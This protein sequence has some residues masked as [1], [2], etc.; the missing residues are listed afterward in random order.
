MKKIV[1]IGVS[2]CKSG[3]LVCHLRVYCTDFGLRENKIGLSLVLVDMNLFLSLSF[4]GRRNK[5]T[6]SCN[7]SSSRS[8]A[9]FRSYLGGDGR[10]GISKKCICGSDVALRT[11][12]VE[13]GRKIFVCKGNTMVSI[14][15]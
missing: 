6:F 1:I 13:E 9:S 10:V 4:T 14:N 8:Q 12:Y 11:S 15:I 2:L 5:M 7:S 3:K